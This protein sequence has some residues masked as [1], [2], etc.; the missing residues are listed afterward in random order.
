M[1]NRCYIAFFCLVLLGL[2]A[3][4]PVRVFLEKEQLPNEVAFKTFAIENQY[5]GKNVYGSTDLDKVFQEKLI[6]SMEKRGYVLDINDPDV[7]LRYNTILSQNQKGINTMAHNPWGWGMYNPYMWRYPYPYDYHRNGGFKVEK[8][9][10]GEVVI[11]F[12][13]TKK[14][15]AILRISAVGE[16]TKP[17]QLEK[18]IQASTERIIAEFDKKLMPLT[19]EKQKGQDLL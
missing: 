16:V 10:L 13:D 1:K 3:C 2:T 11:D 9:N 4:N 19:Q 15:E 5:P 14:D 7:I 18:N 17:K 8:Y 12:I 6:S